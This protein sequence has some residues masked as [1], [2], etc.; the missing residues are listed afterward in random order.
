V[1]DTP[2]NAVIQANAAPNTAGYRVLDN[3]GATVELINLTIRH[4]NAND[5]GGI[6]NNDTLNVLNGSTIG[7]A[8]AGNT[9]GT[10]GGGILNHIA[11]I[12]VL[13]KPE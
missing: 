2:A 12:P 7:G 1:G 10:S 6:Y 3:I 13:T 4:G 9:A 11:V 8:G 5:G